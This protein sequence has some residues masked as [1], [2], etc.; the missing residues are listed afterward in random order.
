MG[1][2][3][4]NIWLSIHY[5]S[6]YMVL[7]M[8]LEQ[9]DFG[10]SRI[11]RNG[12]K[13]DQIWILLKE[14]GSC[15]IL[16]CVCLCICHLNFSSCQLQNLLKCHPDLIKDRLLQTSSYSVFPMLEP[17]GSTSQAPCCWSPAGPRSANSWHGWEGLKGLGTERSGISASPL[18]QGWSALQYVGWILS[19]SSAPIW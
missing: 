9:N 5:E 15:A 1:N 8:R 12:K 2:A 17:A 14:V 13:P 16:K 7:T 3:W 4:Q 19:M 6:S 18:W 11:C 10:I